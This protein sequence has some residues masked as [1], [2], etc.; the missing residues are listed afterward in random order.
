[1]R[2]R[3]IPFNV[4]ILNPESDFFFGI[5]P[6]SSLTMFNSQTGDFSDE[7]LFSNTIFGRQGD[8]QRYSTYSYIDLKT[9]VLHPLYFEELVSL[10]RLYGG[11]ILGTAYATWDDKE[12]DFVRAK[13]LDG[14]TGISFFLSKLNQIKF[15][16]TKSVERSTRIKFIKTFMD[17]CLLSKYVVIPAGMR[18]VEFDDNNRPVEDEINPLY[19]KLLSNAN[20]ISPSLDSEEDT[21][22][23]LLRASMQKS[24][25]DIYQY[26]FKLL[27][28]KRGWMMSKVASRR[29]A[30]TTRNV[31]SSMEV[32][33][34]KL[35]DPRQPTIDNVIVG[36][37]QFLANVRYQF[38]YQLKAGAFGEFFHS[39]GVEPELVDKE[40]LKR[41]SV[42]LNSRTIDKWLTSEGQDKLIAEFTEPEMRYNSIEIDGHYLGLIYQDSKFYK[43]FN[44]IDELP[45]GFDRSFVR[46][47]TYADFYYLTAEPL[48]EKSYGFA[49]RYPVTG[50]ESIQS[51]K[52]YLRTSGHALQ[53]K[54]L[55]DNW[56]ETDYQ[57]LEFPNFA[58]KEPFVETQSV[59]PS[60]LG[61]YGGDFDGDV[62]SCIIV[63]GD[64]AVKEIMDKLK[65]PSSYLSVTGGFIKDSL[66]DIHTYA[67]NNATGIK[68]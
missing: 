24:V 56:E 59:H 23:D 50:A 64:E 41:V 32:G 57:V 26:L 49:T 27:Q 66:T 55:G 68:A 40:T 67:L 19:R 9:R 44:D 5:T 16:E 53:L 43:L 60:S 34:S 21:S 38:K 12:K 13:I 33:T 15:K 62:L 25:N 22:L 51:C 4:S 31:I 2:L 63:Y 7:G 8:K 61:L 3:N 18:D 10:K 65:D 20:T 29:V 58:N 35:G 37:S 46:P 28:G 45:E 1:M 14:Q 30:G 47:V 17:R 42:K 54:K 11:I 6:V 36:L 52:I 39:E 48:V